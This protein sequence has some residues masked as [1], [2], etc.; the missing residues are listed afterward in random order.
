MPSVLTNVG[1]QII[2]NA[3]NQAGSG[4]G[5]SKPDYSA[6]GTGGTATPAAQTDTAL[7]TPVQARIQGTASIQNGATTGNIYRVVATHTA[8]ASRA[9]DE[10]GLYDGPGTGGPPPTGANLFCHANF[11]VINLAN[12]DSLTLTYDVAVT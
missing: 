12:G 3:I 4:I 2:T 10:A 8:D 9:V 1:R 7:A 6:I 5:S 11:T